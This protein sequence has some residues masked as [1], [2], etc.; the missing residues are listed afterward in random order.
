MEENRKLIEKNKEEDEINKT[1]SKDDCLF[2]LGLPGRIIFTSYSLHG[3][4]FI[5]NFII[6]YIILFPS[7]L[8]T[9]EIPDWTKIPFSIIYFIFALF[10]SNILVIPTF[11]F[12]CFPF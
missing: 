10:S 9:G 8:Y 2:G 7:L 11:E 5:Y 12:F 4:F 3:L 6:Q 1:R